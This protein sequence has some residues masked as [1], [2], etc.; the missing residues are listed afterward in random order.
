MG[1]MFVSPRVVQTYKCCSHEPCA[2]QREHV[3]RSVVEQ[4][5]HVR[6]SIGI[7]PRAVER[8]KPL[9]FT[10]KLSVRPH[11]VTETKRRTIGEAGVEPVASQKGGHISSGEG[12]LGEGWG[13][14]GSLGHVNR[15]P[16]ARHGAPCPRSPGAAGARPTFLL[17]A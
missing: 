5:G 6:R 8:G 3:V 9:G 17:P 13:E 14:D 16:R 12:H 15:F 10:K 11:L 4:H 2:A 1:Q 7:E